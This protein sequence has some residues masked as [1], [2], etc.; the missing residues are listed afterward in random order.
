M[1]RC[2]VDEMGRNSVTPC[3][4]PRTSAS[5][6]VMAEPLLKSRGGSGPHRRANARP[7]RD[8]RPARHLPARSST[9]QRSG[10]A[11]YRVNAATAAAGPRRSKSSYSGSNASSTAASSARAIDRLSERQAQRR[12]AVGQLGRET[13]SRSTL[14]PMPTTTCS[15]RAPA[16]TISVSTPASLR[17]VAGGVDQLHVVRPLEARRHAQRRDRARDRG[18]RQQRQRRDLGGGAARAAAAATQYRFSPAGECQLRP[19]RPR[20]PVCASAA[21]TRPARRAR[22]R[23]LRGE[24]AGRRADRVPFERAA[25]AS[26][27]RARARPDRRWAAATGRRSSSA[28]GGGSLH[29]LRGHGGRRSIRTVATRPSRFSRARLRSAGSRRRSRPRAPS[30]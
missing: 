28:W 9:R 14:M 3:T 12:R 16:L 21:I 26:A 25:P 10:S 24:I 22:P 13:P 6:V 23:A 17:R 7:R 29:R 15:T 20:P 19:R 11:A 27:S 18:A 30:A 1:R 4:T 8:R 5:N 2:A